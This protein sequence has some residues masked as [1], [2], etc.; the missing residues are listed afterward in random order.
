MQRNSSE[1]P[2]FNKVTSVSTLEMS[3]RS[4]EACIKAKNWS[5]AID[6]AQHAIQL[7][8]TATAYKLLG[9]AL[10]HQKQWQE[11]QAAYEQALTLQPDSA[12]VHANL[13][14][15]AAHQHQWSEALRYLKLA[16]ALKPE[17]S[18]LKQN[19]EQLWSQIEQSDAALQT[20]LNQPQQFDAIDHQKLGDRLLKREQVDTALQCYENAIAIDPALATAFWNL[21]MAQ[22]QLG[23]Q[24]AMLD[25]YFR[26]LSLQPSWATA[27]EHC[28]LG[29]HFL[30]QEQW[31]QAIA[32]YERA[33]EQDARLADA[34]FGLGMVLQKQ[35]KLEGAIEAYK[36]AIELQPEAWLTHHNLGCV[37]L[38]QKQWSQA[39]EAYKRAIVLNPDYF[40]SHQNLGDVLMR[41]EQ[42]QEAVTAYRRAIELNPDFHWSHYNLGEALAKLKQWDGA[43]EAYRCATKLEPDLP[44]IQG[45]LGR[46]LHRRMATDKEELLNCCEQLIRSDPSNV[47][48]YHQ[49]LEVRPS[50]AELYFKLGHVLREQGKPNEALIFFNIAVQQQPD[51]LEDALQAY[52][53]L[54][55]QSAD[56]TL[57][58]R[59]LSENY[60]NLGRSL[61]KQALKN[62]RRAIGLDPDNLELYEQATKIDSEDAELYFA[63]AKSLIS[64]EHSAQA[65]LHYE[66]G[67]K[68]KQEVEDAQ[69]VSLNLAENKIEHSDPDFDWKFYT[70]YNQDLDRLTTYKA[71][72][73][74]WRT[75]GKAEGRIGSETQFYNIY[76]RDSALPQGFD[77]KEY[78]ELNPDLQPFISS[79]WQAI[80]HFLSSGSKEE[81][82]YSRNQLYYKPPIRADE[83]VLQESDAQFE[84]DQPDLSSEFDWEF[85]TAYNQD[86]SSLTYEEASEHWRTS[87]KAEGRLASEAQL[88]IH[89]GISRADIPS[90]FDWKE[91]LE[92]NLNLHVH[93]KNKWQATAHYITTGRHE[94][95]IYRLEQLRH[96]EDVAE[97]S[98]A[99][100]VPN[101]REP[102]KPKRLAVFFHLYYYDLWE[103]IRSY[104]RNIEEKFDFFINIVES[105]WTPE[106]HE[107]LRRDYPEAR[108]FIS[109]NRGKDIG[110]YLACMDHIDFSNYDVFCTVHTKKS[111]HVSKKLSDQWRTDLLTAILGSKEKVRINLD[112]LRRDPDIGLIGTR[113]WRNTVI[114]EHNV[115]HY[116]RLLDEFNVKAEARKCEYLAGTMMLVRPKI[117]QAIHSRYGSASLEDGD[118]KDLEFQK[119][120]QI[121]HSLERL[122]GNLVRHYGMRFFWQE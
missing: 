121:A 43:I 7:K 91:Y 67:L 78:L 5:Q 9:N 110:G 4:A 101:V 63:L 16:I 69:A 25:A 10:L 75:S 52:G 18:Q 99:N 48:I 31:E 97:R 15:L 68:L 71:A 42:W 13:G 112:I 20:F 65:I 60:I 93:L 55:N 47:E 8:P 40:W 102:N 66:E 105:I 29:N 57:V 21:S 118:G 82:L 76:T 6:H 109:K 23:N 17:L 53:R 98:V 115:E 33:I 117:W 49:V 104:L 77:W 37:F 46:V 41:L 1:Q 122:V 74:H 114:G 120:G 27:E 39:V 116:Y 12:E 26:A 2:S 56:S 24:E 92:L 19:L 45:K 87:G 62:Y 96:R 107:G 80:Q 100:F 85:Y 11:A 113:F 119:D 108:I 72:L 22:N 14:T 30:Q 34:H 61:L 64:Q 88:W 86:L 50:D 84:V 83:R 89:L 36:Q 106:I 28:K 59:K 44:L 70:T 94:G 38:E 54:M 81:K 3:L 35:G 51:A 111:P 73:E 79:K 90:D 32:C 95:R 103:E 58:K